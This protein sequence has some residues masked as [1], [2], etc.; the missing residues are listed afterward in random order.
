M[1]IH[2][3]PVLGMEEVSMNV[4]SRIMSA[5]AAPAGRQEKEGRKE[6]RQ[7]PTPPIKKSNSILKSSTVQNHFLSNT[8]AT[9]VA[10]V[11]LAQL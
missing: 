6:G 8:I 5:A 4:E 9:S 3:S 1:P 2:N 7:E 11:P 10:C